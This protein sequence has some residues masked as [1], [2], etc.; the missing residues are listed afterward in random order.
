MEHPAAVN[1][2]SAATLY[3]AK[4][5]GIEIFSFFSNRISFS[6]SSYLA[7]RPAQVFAEAFS[8]EVLFFVVFVVVAFLVVFFLVVFNVVSFAL[9]FEISDLVEVEA[10]AEVLFVVGLVELVVA[11]SVE[12]EADAAATS[13]FA[14]AVVVCVVL[15]TALELE[16]VEIDSDSCVLRDELV[17]SILEILD[18][19]DDSPEEVLVSALFADVLEVDEER[20]PIDVLAVLDAAVFEELEDEETTGPLEEPNEVTWKLPEVLDEVEAEV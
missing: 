16:A 12:D 7:F 3:P 6:I 8:V 19:L 1:A 15:C 10:L 14:L 13:T 5:G 11:A 18:I 9:D 20:L 17:A 4:Y 2:S